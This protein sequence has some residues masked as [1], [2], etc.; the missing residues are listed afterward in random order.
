MN[1]NQIDGQRQ[2]EDALQPDQEARED[3]GRGGPGRQD[4]V[5]KQSTYSKSWSVMDG[6]AVFKLAFVEQLIGNGTD[7]WVAAV[8][9]V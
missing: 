9:G 3:G 2:R 6:D 7:V 5:H 8:L 1:R 4:E